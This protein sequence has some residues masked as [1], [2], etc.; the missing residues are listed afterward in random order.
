MQSNVIVADVIGHRAR[1]AWLGVALL[2]TIALTVVPLLM[3]DGAHDRRPARI[4]RTLR[5]QHGCT[6]HKRLEHRIRHEIERVEHRA[7]REAERAYQE[8]ERAVREAERAERRAR[9]EVQ[10]AE[11]RIRKDAERADL[12]RDDE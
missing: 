12:L 11:R 1:F 2:A 6:A 10:R 4:E 3:R 7:R 8:A 9:R 5:W